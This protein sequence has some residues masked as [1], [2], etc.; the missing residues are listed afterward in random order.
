[1]TRFLA[2]ERMK[3]A[4]SAALFFVLPALTPIAAHGHDLWLEP[5]AFVTP[6]DHR[7][8]LELHLGHADDPEVQARDGRRIDRF[9]VLGPLGDA[10]AAERPVLGLDGSSP[11]GVLRPDSP[12]RYV[13]GYRSV[14][15]RSELPADRFESYLLEEGLE[16]IRDVRRERGEAEA[17]G[18]E[19]FSRAAKTLVAVGPLGEGAETPAF[20][21][22]LGF[23]LELTVEADPLRWRDGEALPLRLWFED[24]PVAGVRVD[25]F[26]L[27]AP[28]VTLEGRTDESGRVSFALPRA[29]RWV[30]AAVHMVEAP[31]SAEQ[32]W[33]SIWASLSLH[34]GSPKPQATP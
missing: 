33:Q 14:D 19:L 18:S 27:E 17:P 3:R 29:G 6:V 8:D 11:A 24:A 4:V 25:A 20:D 1:M 30:I 31:A 21:H 28:W 32:D 5:S 10:G 16:A 22:R 34:A 7:L 13:I 2:R 23:R 15:A 9:V 26:S 12:G